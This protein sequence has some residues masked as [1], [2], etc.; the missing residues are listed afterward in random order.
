MPSFIKINKRRSSSWGKDTN[1]GREEK[2]REEK[3]R[4]EKRREEKRREEKRR[5]N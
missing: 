4:E 5:L 1:G 3:R 2:R